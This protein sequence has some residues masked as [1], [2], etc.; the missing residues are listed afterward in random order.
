MKRSLLFFWACTAFGYQSVS[1]PAN[2]SLA[3]TVPN[4][5]PFN[6]LGD[7]RLSFRLHNWTQPASG[8]ANLISVPGL[9]VSLTSSGSLCATDSA[10]T[11]GYYGN[12]DC[13]SVA[14][15]SDIVVRIQR[16][17]TTPIMS[18]FPASFWIEV[19][20][21][22]T[23]TQPAQVCGGWSP[24]GCPMATGGTH[25]WVTSSGA[26]GA[27][28]GFSLAWLKWSS[29][30]VLPTVTPMET[31]ASPADLA[32]FRFEG[33][34][35]NQGT[36]AYAVTLSAGSGV[37]SFSAS[38]LKAPRCV[39]QRQILHAGARGQQLVS[40]S[41]PLDGGSSLTYA[42]QMVS[43]PSTLLW[44]SRTSESPLVS[45]GIF[46]SYVFSLT[47]TDS[48]Q[49]SSSCTVKDGFVAVD[50]NG[51]VDTGNAQVNTILGP[52]IPLYSNPWPW[53]DDRMVAEAT[54]QVANLSAYYG[55]TQGVTP[56]WNV[57]GPGTI[58][59]AS[60]STAV[61]GAGTTFTTTF[62]QGPTNPTVPQS[63]ARIIVWYP[64]ATLREGAGRRQMVV[65]GCT[66]DTHL[67]IGRAW[68]DQGFL[69]AGSG[70]NYSFI[71]DPTWGT[72]FSSS[73]PANFYD[74]VLAFYS[75]YYR[76]G[77]D[78][79]LN[80]ARMVADNFWQLMLD[81]G[82]DYFYGE[83]YNTF[84]HQRSVLGMVMRAIDGR[85]DMWSGIEMIAFCNYASYH[86]RFNNYGNWTSIGGSISNQAFGDPR[87]DGYALGEEAYCALFDP[88]PSNA[89]ACRTYISEVINRGWTPSRFSDGNFYS[90]YWGGM[91]GGPDS[92]NYASFA[93]GTYVT[94]T[95]GSSTVQCHNGTGTC[96]WQASVFSSTTPV[97]FIDSITG[98][99]ASNMDGDRVVYCPVYVSSTQLT[100][101]DCNGNVVN[102]QGASGS[103]GWVLSGYGVV[104]YGIQPYML[105]IAATMMDFAAK[106]MTCT[107][108]GTPTNCNNTVATNAHAYNVQMAN[109]LRQYGYRPAMKGV[110][111]FT[112][113][114]N[115]PYPIPESNINCTS[116][117]T[118]PQAR[119]LSA[120]ALRGVMTAYGYNRDSNLMAFGDTLYNAMWNK[121]GWPAP[122][123]STADGAYEDGYENAFGWYITGI[124]PAGTA[125][126]Y[127]GMGWGI[128]AGS[129]W[130]AYRVGGA[131]ASTTV[132]SSVAVNLGFVPHAVAFNLVVTYPTGTT[133]TVSCAASP[134]SVPLDQTAGSAVIHIQ[135]L[136][137][138][139]TVIATQQYPYPLWLN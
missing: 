81:S 74:I 89:A 118:A 59:V 97:W 94:L 16:L 84:E 57:A 47:V 136:S 95:N 43:G 119:N 77:I 42:W 7:Y 65:T 85:P 138:A 125:H 71:S 50:Q 78:D 96:N 110:Y 4:S 10:D 15:L 48:H 58:T 137:A 134:C 54:V 98:W 41:F 27:T 26:I 19:Q 39:L 52:M 108:T 92:V 104:G 112:S 87:E 135:Y 60:N 18:T 25:S 130:P 69:T 93:S 99:P 105:G 121:S 75:L 117:Y 124:P 62:C 114:V 100:L 129:D 109:Y 40:G 1:I 101:Q 33:G 113:F 122:S 82:R 66:D 68:N 76:S 63:N 106:A 51:V 72:W 17:G 35:A 49:Q 9:Q 29:V 90:F 28:V 55:L 53:Y 111:Y 116:G 46:G 22:D 107:S 36:G 20:D 34:Y 45:G 6:A 11:D 80:A 8:T 115:C 127:F 32:D 103:H 14:G 31:E 23:G 83:G 13:V 24:T 133:V 21:L 30:T 5:A 79:Y 73:A 131:H 70:W 128:S 37:P 132:N 64:Q 67:T 123:G 38:P 44:S 3:L 2:A 120:E 88:D 56:S 91:G 61:V 12:G 86:D 102:Y 126:K 139:H